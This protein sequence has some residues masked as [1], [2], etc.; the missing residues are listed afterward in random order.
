MQCPYY[1]HNALAPLF[2]LPADQIRVV[3]METGGGFGGKEEYPVDDRRPRGA[4]RVEVGAAGEDDLRPRRGHGRDDQAASV[5]DAASHRGRRATAGCVAM[6]IDFVIDG[7]A[8]CTLSPVVLSRGTIHA[9]GPYVC[10]NVRVRGRA[11]ATNAPPHGAFRGFGA[12]QSIFALERH[13]DTRRRGGRPGARGVPPPQLHPARA[14]TLRSARRSRE[15]VDMAGAARSRAASCRGYHE[16][17]AA[18]R[19]RR[20]RPRR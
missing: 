11:V 4:A 9:A 12:P 3:Q 20:T 19:A 6:D 17:R 1:I 5:A 14:D 18:L 7:G 15:P 10:P 2:G 16:K 8:Y 13:M